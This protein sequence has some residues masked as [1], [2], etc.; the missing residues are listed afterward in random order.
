MAGDASLIK[1]RESGDVYIWDP[2]T[3]YVPG[4]SAPVD[5]SVALATGWKAAGLMLG[6]PGV[7]ITRSIERTDVNS[8]QQGRVLERLKNPKVDL[9][10]TLLEDNPTVLELV[11]QDSVPTVSKRYLL[12]EF[13]LEDGKKER[14]IS[15]AE[16]RLFVSSDD[17]GQD[18][19]G[20]EISASLV[21]V[22]GKYWA[23]L[24]PK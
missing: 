5:S 2:G 1:V 4:T 10:F 13:L 6:D 20:R 19:K 8:W 17:L 18:V 9:N 3:A 24:P 23:I 16:A 11:G 12:L 21:P 7:G 14:W 22:S 15:K